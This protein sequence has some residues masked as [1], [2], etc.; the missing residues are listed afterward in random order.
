MFQKRFAGLVES[1]KKRQTVRKTPKRMPR[2]GDELS[3]R[4]WTGQPY[5]SKQRELKAAQVLEIE[6]IEIFG[7][8][9]QVGGR[10]LTAGQREEFAKADGFDDFADFVMWFRN[11]HGLPFEGIALF[12]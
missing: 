1:G 6:E 2:K 5:R 11:T 7:D 3:L 4:E 8:S 9:I 12:W 10:R